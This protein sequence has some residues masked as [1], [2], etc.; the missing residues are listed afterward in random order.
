MCGTSKAYH[1]SANEEVQYQ[2]GTS[3]SFG[4]RELLKDAFE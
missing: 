3:S 2:R 4:K 1:Q